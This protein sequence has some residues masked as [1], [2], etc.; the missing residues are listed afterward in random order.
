MEDLKQLIEYETG[1]RFNR[2]G[3]IVCPFHNEKTGS[4]R[5]KFDS[6]LN[7]EIFHCFGCGEHGDKI[8]FIKKIKNINYE[9]ALEYL[10]IKVDPKKKEYKDKIKT[11][12]D[13]YIKN[14]NLKLI[15]LFPYV[16]KENNII[17]YKVKFKDLNTVKKTLTYF[18]VAEN[19]QVI[20]KRGTDIEYPYNLY[21]ALKII[22]NKGTII[23]VEGEKDVNTVNS[24]NL[25]NTTAISVKNVKNL[26]F[27]YGCNLILCGDTGKAGED[28]IKHLTT[29]L[30]E[31]AKTF[32]ILRLTEINELGDNKDVT[33]WFEEGYTKQD[34][35][36]CI[37]KSLDEKDKYELQQNKFGV[38]K[39]IFKEKGDEIIEKTIYLTNFRIVS[40]SKIERIDDETEGLKI[41]FKTDDNNIIE[42]IGD[43]TVFD[44]VKSFKA[45]LNSMSLTFIGK[46]DDLSALKIWI[47]KYFIDNK[48]IIY[49]NAGF[50]LLE[51]K[52]IFVTTAGSVM[53]GNK[54]NKNVITD[55]L[56][57]TSSILN[58]D[59]ITEEEFK[60][61]YKY[62]FNFLDKSK[63]YS[64]IGTIINN[65]FVMQNKMNDI[66]LNH[67]LI[68]GESGSGKST[69]LE[70][71]ISP[72]LGVPHG[73]IKSIGLISKF[74]LTK[75]LSN[76]NMTALF[77]EFK[78]SRMDRIHIATTSEMLRN[79]Y[80]R[81]TVSRGTKSLKLRQ[82]TLERPIVIAGEESYPSAEK[83]LIE[84]SNIIYISRCERT[85]KNIESMQWLKNNQDILRK[86]GRTL[87][88]LSLETNT[89]DFLMVRNKLKDK[90]YSL[91]NRPLETLINALNGMYYFDVLAKRFNCNPVI[92][93]A[94]SKEDKYIVENIEN[95][96]LDETGE[97]Y[98]V[99]E[100]MI[101]LFN[102]LIVDERFR[103]TGD[104]VLK[105]SQESDIYI[106]TAEMINQ[107]KE[108]IKQVDS[109]IVIL[110]KKDFIK[111]AIKAGYIVESGVRKR[112]NGRQKRFEKF[113]F[114]KLEPLNVDSLL[115]DDLTDHITEI[116]K[117]KENNITVRTGRVK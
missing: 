34:F 18:H 37:N 42:R 102:D 59:V 79:S 64:I 115:F 90:N 44:D 106:R 29:E 54:I 10:G 26:E 46:I 66:K 35:I 111:Q 56:E 68:V 76:G 20:N 75:H 4:L 30:K 60:E 45:F 88:N 6:N 40:A 15:G 91:K 113:S 84:R 53:A 107:L 13:N 48:I 112:I 78:P 83:A 116:Y 12:I 22:E 89:E 43:T 97:T 50:K 96:V 71:V 16:N 69:I 80:D 65:L 51:D 77:D 3:Y 93:G 94:D 47:N 24:L 32:K 11:A 95:E 1:K 82:F 108:Y 19:G 92:F 5:V 28:Y 86:L 8:D 14:K 62:L 55:S 70:N 7:K 63:T 98:S 105:N 27:L 57:N 36:N 21:K 117:D 41:I 85:E 104:N 72:I 101:I 31:K 58:C 99:V 17:Y 25:Y 9:E 100:Q 73:E 52:L 23:I 74:A 81:T 103:N 38:Y 67:L 33:D 110:D 114:E 49:N 2:N 39:T 61:L 87:I 109:D